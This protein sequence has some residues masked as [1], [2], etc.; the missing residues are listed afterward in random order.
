MHDKLKNTLNHALSIKL[1]TC[2]INQLEKYP[3]ELIIEN[4]CVGA[5][6]PPLP[7]RTSLTKCQS[8][9]IGFF[10]SSRNPRVRSISGL[11]SDFYN[12]EHRPN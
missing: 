12:A 6:N 9:Q 11:R 1:H 4:P 8:M 7:P 5:W 10:F 2:P 3:L